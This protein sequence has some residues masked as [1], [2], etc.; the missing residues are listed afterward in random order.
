MLVRIDLRYVDIEYELWALGQFLELIEPQI[1]RLQEQ[2]QAKIFEELRQKGWDH[3]EYELQRASEELHE[4]QNFV[5]PRFMRGPFLI[6][7]WACYEAG[8]GELAD[9]RRREIGAKLSMQEIRGGDFLGRARRYFDAVLGIPL[10]T[11]EAR[12]ARLA[13]L[14]I[15]RNS[16]AHA[17]GQQC[18][19]RKGD[20][21]CVSGTLARYG[22]PPGDSRGVIVI[23]DA[24]L[25]RAYDDVNSS[26]LD[27]VFRVRGG[28]AFVKSESA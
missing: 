7:L 6:A 22:A 28:P 14:S 10:D 2:D 17:N 26:L 1:K 9:G 24:Y 11:D 15:V 16:L 12:Y 8:V 4:R 13:E 19:M 18:W 23:P 5:I 21:E 27:L 25:R 3:D 20:W